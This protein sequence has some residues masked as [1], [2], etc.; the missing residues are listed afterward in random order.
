[1]ILGCW[2]ISPQERPTFNELFDQINRIIEKNQIE[3]TEES[4]QSLQKDW[5]QEIQDMFNELKEK[6]QVI[7]LISKRKDLFFSSSRKSVIVNKR[8]TNV[9]WNKICNV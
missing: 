9:R 4:Y 5:R 3:S 6:E 2:K 1:M 8:C 7:R